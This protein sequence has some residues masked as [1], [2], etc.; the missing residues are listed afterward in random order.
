M[1]SYTWAD[2]DPDAHTATTRRLTRLRNRHPLLLP[3]EAT[4][5]WEIRQPMDARTITPALFTQAFPAGVDI[6]MTSSPMLTQHLP[7]AH[8][9][10]AHPAHAAISQIHRLIRHLATL[11]EGGIGFVWDTPVG[12]PLP[13]HISTMM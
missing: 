3:P 13:A 8:N 1:A 9:G 11:Q 10:Q 5:G 12:S 2:I 7:R 4:E 6:I